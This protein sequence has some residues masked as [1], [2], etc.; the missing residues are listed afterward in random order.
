MD[1]NCDRV[2]SAA[3]E[4]RAIVFKKD[5]MMLNQIVQFLYIDATVVHM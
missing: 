5:V 1:V 2:C 4:R 3:T